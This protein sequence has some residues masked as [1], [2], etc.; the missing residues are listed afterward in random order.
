[1]MGI[2]IDGRRYEVYS[3]TGLVLLLAW[4]EQQKRDQA[5]AA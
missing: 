3:E 4:L 1:M 2:T 5:H